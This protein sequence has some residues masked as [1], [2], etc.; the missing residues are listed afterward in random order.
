MGRSIGGHHRSAAGYSGD[1]LTPPD[2]LAR[3]GPFD[4]DPCTPAAMPWPTAARRYTPADD[5][6]AQPWEGRVWLNPPYGRETGR[7][8]ERL[9][10]HG[11]GVAL[12]FART[13]TAMFWRWVW[14]RAAGL[15]F[16]KGRLAFLR[17]DGT[18]AGHNSGGPSVL[19]AYGT[20][21]VQALAGSGLAGVLV[22]LDAARRAALPLF[23]TEVSP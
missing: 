14:T 21:N 6:L 22:E 12:V 15:L 1:W 16:L 13:E 19:I 3:L 23:G 7:W 20:R 10:R 17:T 18:K 2:L 9:A 8:L 11:D 4:L 5:G